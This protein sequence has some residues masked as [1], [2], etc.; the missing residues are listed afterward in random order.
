MEDY[1]MK[2]ATTNQTL[3]TLMSADKKAYQKYLREKDLIPEYTAYLP[4]HMYVLFGKIHK[5][6][7]Y[8]A[9]GYDINTPD[10][11]G[12]TAIYYAMFNDDFKVMKLLIDNGA[13]YHFVD[14]EVSGC[15]L[16]HLAA[17]EGYLDKVKYMVET[18][19]LSLNDVDNHNHTPLSSSMLFSQVEVAEYL[20]TQGAVNDYQIQRMDTLMVHLTKVLQKLNKEIEKQTIVPLELLT[21]A[22]RIKN[23]MASV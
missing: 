23:F 19:G 5:I 2:T 12:R 6:K 15:T 4:L 8:I 17:T 14:R 9:T 10:V 7:E 1:T 13:D 18:L 22:Q 20:I 16:L 21:T 3:N 11:F